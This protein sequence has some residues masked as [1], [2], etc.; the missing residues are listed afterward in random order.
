MRGWPALKDR[1]GHCVVEGPLRR[2]TV[3]PPGQGIR[4]DVLVPRQVAGH[5]KDVVFACT[6]SIRPVPD[7]TETGTGSRP[8]C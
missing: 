1:S 2:V 8:P 5:K 3:A 4:K 6:M 7:G